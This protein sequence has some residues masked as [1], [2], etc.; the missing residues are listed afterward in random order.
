MLREGFDFATYDNDLALALIS[1]DNPLHLDGLFASAISLP[2]SS[3]DSD[4]VGKLGRVAG[5]GSMDGSDLDFSPI[6]NKVDLPL[7]SDEVCESVWGGAFTAGQKLCAGTLA[8][9]RDTCHGDSGAP[10]VVDGVV[11]GIVSFGEGCG[12]VDR[13]GVYVRVSHYVKWIHHAIRLI[14]EEGNN[15]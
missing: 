13:L 14:E 1:A 3:Y 5:W 8:G 12:Q 2:S 10:L 9:G 15:L 7:Q 4:L 11:V 6:L